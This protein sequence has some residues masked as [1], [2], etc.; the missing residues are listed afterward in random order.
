LTPPLAAK[1]VELNVG[2][3]ARAAVAAIM[4]DAI[5]S[6]FVFIISVFYKLR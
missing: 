3:S 2:A 6:V 5:T 4:T 1:A